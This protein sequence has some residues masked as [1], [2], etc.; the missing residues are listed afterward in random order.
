MITERLRARCSACRC[1]RRARSRGAPRMAVARAAVFGNSAATAC[2]RAAAARVAAA[3]AG[4]IGVADDLVLDAR[5]ALQDADPRRAQL[6]HGRRAQLGAA[7]R[8]VGDDH[9]VAGRRVDAVPPARLTSASSTPAG[10]AA[11]ARS[12][13]SYDGHTGSTVISPISVPPTARLPAVRWSCSTAPA[14]SGAQVGWSRAPARRRPVATA[15]GAGRC[16]TGGH[17][18]WACTRQMLR[19]WPQVPEGPKD[20]GHPGGWVRD[21]HPPDR[22]RNDPPGTR[23]LKAEGPRRGAHRGHDACVGQALV[24]GAAPRWSR[25]RTATLDVHDVRMGTVHRLLLLRHAKSSWDQPDL[26]DH[27]RPLAPRGRRAATALGEHLRGPRRTS[28]P[29]AVL[30]GGA[31]R[32]DAAA[33]PSGPA[34]G[35]VRR[36]R[37]R[38]LRRR[39]RRAARPRPAAAV[40]GRRACCSSGTTRGSV[41]SP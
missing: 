10:D 20:P 33:D 12:P 5:L 3:L 27:D 32:G 19:V 36:G 4:A 31:D 26:A 40:D 14:S 18:C 30:V 41:T 13:R 8:E 28:R 2:A 7:D 25:S 15:A 6:G 29:R 9:R 35:H 23:V 39:R 16:R 34:G 17:A 37:G 38:A 22:G 11:R 21:R 24:G 1:R